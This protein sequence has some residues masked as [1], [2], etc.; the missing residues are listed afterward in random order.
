M[1]KKSEKNMPEDKF[2]SESVNKQESSPDSLKSNKALIKKSEKTDSSE[3]KEKP[4]KPKTPP[5]KTTA[6]KNTSMVIVI[7]VLF[8]IAVSGIGLAAYDFWLLRAQAPLNA[9]LAAA[10]SGFE[11]RLMQLEQQ[12][13]DIER[14]SRNVE[15]QLQQTQNQLSAEI[16]ARKSEQQEHQAVNAALQSIT[17]K[18]GRNTIAWRMAEVEYLLTVANHRLMLARDRQTAIA[19]FETADSRLEAIADPALLKVRKAIASELTALRAVPNVDI[20]GLALQIGSLAET[21]EQLPLMDKKR[22][23][24]VTEK[25]ENAAS[26]DWQEIPTAV[27]NDIKSLVQVRR[28]Q[29]PTEPLLPPQQAWFL[30]QNL[31]LKLEQARLAVLKQN[32]T[33]FVQSLE[34]V[35][36]WLNSYFDV[37]SAAVISLQKTIKNLRT[38]ELQPTLPD[39][40]SSL[41]ELRSVMNAATRVTTP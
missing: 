11:T 15:Q 31:Q 34:E 6:N 37:E 13:R 19:V 38:I 5:T 4:S 9:Q 28:H 7:G 21:V 16:Q 25:R 2:E 32:T 40:S 22:L 10:Q 39:V 27:W 41:R 26:I 17:E 29:Q 33:V 30:Y 18:L 3:V 23:A 14:H 35:S 1:M 8:V 36:Q 12:S 20:P 24:M